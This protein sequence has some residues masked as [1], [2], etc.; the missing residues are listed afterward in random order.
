MKTQNKISCS[1][2]GFTLMELL[3]AMGIFA[4]VAAVV[5]GAYKST[6]YTIENAEYQIDVSGRVQTFFDRITED[7]ELIYQGENS[8]FEGTQETIDAQRADRLIMVSAADLR[9]SR[10]QTGGNLVQLAYF[11]KRNEESGLL[12]IYR[13]ETAFEPDE[14]VDYESKGF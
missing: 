13:S 9:L 3:I 8:Y 6:F 2:K 10:E 12:D 4:I 14:E 1:S 11:A 5:Y 7:I